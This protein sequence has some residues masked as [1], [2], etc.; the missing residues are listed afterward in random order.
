MRGRILAMPLTDH[1][2]RRFDVIKLLLSF[3]VGAV[4]LIAGA[5]R[6]PIQAWGAKY[7][8]LAALLA[9]LV[10]GVFLF[11]ALLDQMA[12]DVDERA[13]GRSSLELRRGFVFLLIGLLSLW[14]IAVE[15]VWK[16]P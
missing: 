9:F 6:S 10:S 12:A 11:A 7:F 15:V 8:V 5:F 13:T 4:A 2:A 16:W 14:F 3:D 1:A